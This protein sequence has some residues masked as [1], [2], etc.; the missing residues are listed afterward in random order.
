M[1]I[2]RTTTKS[3][4]FWTTLTRNPTTLLHNLFLLLL[5]NLEGQ[6]AL[7]LLQFVTTT[8]TILSLLTKERHQLILSLLALGRT[9]QWAILM[10]N[11]LTIHLWLRIPLIYQMP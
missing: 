9:I 10:K 6:L 1:K 11:M 2:P 5:L 4:P 7:I 8:T 3:K